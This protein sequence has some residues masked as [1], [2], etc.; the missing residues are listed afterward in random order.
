M[1]PELSLII[2]EGSESAREVAVDS[3]RFTI[4][5]SP[6]NDLVITDSNLS[7]RHALVECFDGI[8]Q[9]SDCGS[10]NGT[11]L[12]SVAVTGAAVLSDGDVITL[13][14]STEI[15]V[16]IGARASA[17][18][19]TKSSAVAAASAGVSE[20]RAKPARKIAKRARVKKDRT[21]QQ[22]PPP[23]IGQIEDSD[24]ASSH[25][26]LSAPVIAACSVVVILLIVVVLIIFMRKGSADV[27]KVD[28]RPR[29]TS[30]ESTAGQTTSEDN[31]AS[32]QSTLDAGTS[33]GNATASG[34]TASLDQVESAAGQVMLRISSDDRPYSFSEK[35]LHDIS[36]R[37]EEYRALP[38]TRDAI[39]AMQR[40]GNAVATQARREGLEPGLVVYTGLLMT[41]G[42]RSGRDPVAA[43]REMIPNL[44]ALRATFGSG[45]ADSSLIVLAAYKEGG[46][47]TKQSHPL[48]EK[49]RR[50]V[51]NPLV[52]RNIWYLHER[53]GLS[54]DAYNFVVRFIAL[55]AIAQNPRQFGVA[56]DPL[57]F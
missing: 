12:N 56:A 10:R 24:W 27:T 2:G 46:V 15:T 28:R 50:L 43:A 23:R 32:Q 5:R 29:A 26:W 35:A 7:R 1:Q 57:T 42:G 6:D 37:I 33:N 4:G 53:G 11:Q 30:S 17:G 41:D 39:L 18:S 49:M 3:M 9:V 25:G 13:G 19:R 34:N 48:L 54:E 36:Q 47:G 16:R 22:V 40:G 52:Q 38:S 14:G 21:S 55:G 44:L 51:K 8:A 45:D 31:Q 20:R